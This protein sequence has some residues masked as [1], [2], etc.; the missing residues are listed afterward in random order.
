MAHQHITLKEKFT[1][2]KILAESHADCYSWQHGCSA[3]LVVPV[4]QVV[5]P[6]FCIKVRKH[7]RDIIYWKRL[8]RGG[9]NWILHRDIAPYH[10]CHRASFFDEPISSHSSATV[11]SVSYCAQHLAVAETLDWA[12]R[13]WVYVHIR[14]SVECDSRSHGRTKKRTW[15]SPFSD[16]KRA[17]LLSKYFYCKL[18]LNSVK[19]LI[20]QCKWN[21]VKT[22]LIIALDVCTPCLQISKWYLP[23]FQSFSYTLGVICATAVVMQFFISCKVHTLSWCL[24][25]FMNAHQEVLCCEAWWP[26][27]A[28]S[29]DPLI[30]KSLIQWSVHFIVIMRESA[31]L[32]KCWFMGDLSTHF[33]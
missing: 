18:C 28:F 6:V 3:P 30:K 16:S 2:H 1:C 9:K 15:R 31:T 10:V 32:L 25:F 13:L 11:F 5:N 4:G 26:G 7:L 8:K 21:G 23:S 29:S 33:Q 24:I 20:L 14:I 19:F 22:F 17:L 27:W 12:Q